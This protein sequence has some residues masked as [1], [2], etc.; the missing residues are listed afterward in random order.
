MGKENRLFYPTGIKVHPK[1]WDSKMDKVKN[2]AMP[3]MTIDNKHVHEIAGYQQATRDNVNL[4]FSYLRTVVD[5]ALSSAIVK[6]TPVTKEYLENAL[7]AYNNPVVQP[8]RVSFFQFVDAFINDLE[9][10]KRMLDGNK[11]ADPKTVQRYKTAKN[12]LLEFQVNQKVMLDFG[13]WTEEMWNDYIAF[14][15][16]VKKFKINNIGFYQ[17]QVK[18]IL[19]AARKAKLYTIGE[20]LDNAK[21]LAESPV[22]V[23]LNKKELAILENYDLSNN[24]RLERVRD[25]FLI[26]CNTGFR[27]SD[28]KQV[29]KENIK[30]TASGNLYIEVVPEKSNA[31]PPSC[32]LQN[33]VVRILDKYNGVLPTISEQKFNQYI[34][35]LCELVGIDEL[36]TT[37]HIIAGRVTIEL[38][39]KY[40]QVS[41]HTARRSYATNMYLDGLPT[42]LIMKATGHGT[43]KNF[44]KYLK[45]DNSGA[46][47]AMADHIS[48]SEKALL[49]QKS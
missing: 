4:Y 39:N 18:V 2:V 45:L 47:D 13:N 14:L 31:T 36:V 40:T 6:R 41:S 11:I 12:N 43:E 9:S 48:R 3:E 34:K 24:E 16:F 32:H 35:E 26:G 5:E 20:W 23:Y 37:K 38:V 19:K 10:G 29:K 46:V 42:Y 49:S 28:W 44:I 7:D 15:T 17:K 27:I 22:D 33:I 30:K 1:F 21:I 8:S 25:L